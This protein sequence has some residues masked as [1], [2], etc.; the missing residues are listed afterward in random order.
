MQFNK[1]R[2]FRKKS[3]TEIK[4]EVKNV[5]REI[6]SSLETSPIEWIEEKEDIALYAMVAK[7]SGFVGLL[8]VELWGISF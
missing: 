5:V 8:T 4:L 1:E 2:E 7:L 6:K 3:Q